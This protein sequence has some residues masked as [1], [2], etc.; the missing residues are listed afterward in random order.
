MSEPTTE[1]RLTA[2]EARLARI[3]QAL[4]PTAESTPPVRAA[5]AAE[6]PDTP[7]QRP[8]LL[9]PQDTGAATAPA[10]TPK[11]ADK[12]LSPAPSF[13]ATQLL[14]W[15]GAT[16]LVLAA[17]YLIRL[18]IDSGWLTPLRQLALAAFGGGGLIAGGLL[19][20]RLDRH[21]AAFLPAAG[22]VVLYATV[23]G[24]HLYYGLIDGQTAAFGI[25]ALTLLALWLG[26][27]F[28]SEL[29]ALFAAVGSYTAPLFLPELRGAIGDL[30][31]YFTAWSVA[32]A[33]YA[34]MIQ[35]RSV[36]LLAMYLALVVF[37]LLFEQ[38]LRGAWQGALLFQTLQFAIFLAA[39][40]V[41]SIRLDKPMSSLEGWYHFPALLLFYAIQ[42]D[43]LNRHLSDYAPWI[44]LATAAALLATY[45]LARGRLG[46]SAEAGRALVSAYLALVLT[47]SVYM[48]LLPDGFTPWIGLALLAVLPMLPHARERGESVLAAWPFLFAGGMILLFNMARVLLNENMSAVPAHALLLMLYPVLSYI[49]YVRLRRDEKAA[50]WAQLL[51]M[52]AHLSAMTA[53]AHLIDTPALVSVA[54]LAVAS[55]ALAGGFMLRDRRLGQS[56]LL[57]FLLAG[58]K[59]MLFD[60]SDTAPLLRVGVLLVLGISLYAGGWVYRKLPQGDAVK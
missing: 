55:L 49:A 23:Y 10:S 3:E 19:L 5:P 4:G 21:Y 11:R 31:I 2:I 7:A 60:L 28:S 38:H 6:A 39:A 34:L 48:N 37:S 14:G 58:L 59:I 50:H 57:L 29:Y 47:H 15:S 43:L 13:G 12:R 16:A 45:L 9:S 36:Y 35:R 18:G 41:F 56:S 22:I 30:V 44:A 54:W 27:L 8:A 40:A 51:L 53:A 32:F 33:V 24:A 1:Q 46:A 17:L 25:I 20:R 52:L 42:Y 26:D